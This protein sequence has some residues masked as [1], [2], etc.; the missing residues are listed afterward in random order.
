[1]TILVPDIL[2][3]AN[4]TH[5]LPAQPQTACHVKRPHFGPTPIARLTHRCPLGSV[6]LVWAKVQDYQVVSDTFTSNK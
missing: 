4:I 6:M 1:M 2:D 3:W 5:G